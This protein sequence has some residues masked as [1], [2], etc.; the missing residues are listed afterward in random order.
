MLDRKQFDNTEEYL[1]YAWLGLGDVRKLTIHNKMLDPEWADG[2]RVPELIVNTCRDPEY[3]HFFAK[4]VLN[5]NL[6]PIQ[7]A[8]LNVMW[9]TP[10]PLLLGSRGSAKSFMLAVYAIMR[11]VLHQG[12]TIVVVGAALRQSLVL[13]NY[14]SNIWDNAPVLQDICGGK[15][16]SPKKDLSM[17]YWRAGNSKINFLPLG[18]GEKIRGQRACVDGNTLV[19]TTKGLIKISDSAQFMNNPEF[20]VF[21]NKTEPESPAFF[22]KT[23]PIPSYKIK[24][25]GNYEIICSDIHKLMTESGWKYA[26]DLT[27][28][29]KV[30]FT[31]SDY[32]PK[33]YVKSGDIVLDEKLAFLFGMLV[34]EGSISNKHS[35]DVKM[36]DEYCID[37][38]HTLLNELFPKANVCRYE[39]EGRFDERWNTLCKK[40]YE[41]KLCDVKLR[42]QL[43]GLGLSRK[44]AR[45][46]EIPWSILQSPK[47]VVTSFLKGLFWGDGSVFLYK[48]K[49]RE[50]NLGLAYYT[51]SENLCNQLQTLISKYGI[52]VTRSTRASKLSRKPQYT[53][54]IYG[55][56]AVSFAQQI[57]IPKYESILSECHIP[58]LSSKD[59]RY[60]PVKSV[61]RLE[62]MCLYDYNLPV[63]HKFIGNCFTNHN[64]CVIAD[65]F[66]SIDDNIFQ[67]VVRGFASTRSDGVFESVSREAKKRILKDQGV[68]FDDHLEESVKVKNVLGG[69]QIIMSGTPS[70][71]FNH[72][73][74]YY[75]QY[76]TYI[77][78]G[79]DAEYIR[80]VLG[81]DT[82]VSSTF[83]PKDYAVIR[84]PSEVLPEGMMD[85]KI[86]EQAKMTMDK[87]LYLMEY[88]ACGIPGQYIILDTGVKKIEDVQIGDKVLTHRG[89]FRKVL[90]KTYR[91]VD[92]RLVQLKTNGYNKPLTFTKEHPFWNGNDDF[93]SVES[94]DSFTSLSN[95]TELNGKTILTDQLSNVTIPLNYKFGLSLG[96]Y[97]RGNKCD[98]KIVDPTILYSNPDLLKGFIDGYLEGSGRIGSNNLSSITQLKVALSYFGTPSN[99]EELDD[100][101]YVL[102]IDNISDKNSI[103]NYKILEKELIDYSGPVYNFEIEEDN[104]YSLHTATVHNCFPND[105]E[106]FFLASQLE[107]ATCPI[108]TTDGE[109]HFPA[110]LWNDMGIPCVM[111]IDPASENDNF[112]ISIMELM[113]ERRGLIYVWSTNRKAFEKMKKDGLIP[114]HIQDYHTFCIYH[115][116]DLTRRFNI[117]MIVCDA[118]GGGASIREGLKDPDK[119]IG[120]DVAILD[121]D[122]ETIPMN[123]QGK[124]ILKMIEFSS[125]KWRNESHYGLRKDIT[126]KILLFPEHDIAEIELASRVNVNSYETLEDCYLEILESK[127]ETA[128]IK[129]SQTAN[130]TE[131]WS[132]PKV[133]GLDS[134]EINKRLKKD[135]F[136]SML[137]AN[138]GC[139]MINVDS[140][141]R[142]NYKNSVHY[143]IKKNSSHSVGKSGAPPIR[144][145]Q[146]GN[147]RKIFL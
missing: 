20:K 8:V 15:H 100:G 63:S 114:E 91:I 83:N 34:S 112:A 77:E 130:G 36:T 49:Q 106:G 74:K 51:G 147:G 138:W 85:H 29:D 21:T 7:T 64:T 24:A 87:A 10:F 26:K 13:F 116:R 58:K 6:L 118:Q 68:V 70:Y 4:Y 23:K 55:A 18:T 103:T 9:H 2:S 128:M 3:L 39:Y 41:V 66:A 48:C 120:N 17:A 73:Y 102:T 117:Q 142:A 110:K 144:V 47:S 80:S 61:E 136:T 122:D 75:N 12:S 22:I 86:L 126:E 44:K 137:L 14:V 69:N 146:T 95:L 50:N 94:I 62:D 37:L 129:H 145:I 93:V 111:G 30:E 43:V 46:K 88:G 107:S 1:D 35:I 127:T 99:I 16:G 139:R 109:I 135:R 125:A 140:A 27:T 84:I 101:F 67:V 123:A 92:E 104:T 90:K 25:M 82:P 11:A 54:R 60:L 38:I 121:M 105:S 133:K 81:E 97:A 115:I 79:G 5:I 98:N 143:L 141:N 76:K 71:R 32:F 124:R 57:Y 28:E 31:Y 56:A 59:Y 40:M 96:Q 113:G 19:E 45:E 42:D 119:M 53:I 72:F 108:K 52:F 65:E 132:V 131:Q 33:E 78:S 134:E 89:R